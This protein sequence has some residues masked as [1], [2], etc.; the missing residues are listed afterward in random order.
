[1]DKMAADKDLSAISPE[2]N[3]FKRA[4]EDKKTGA[5]EKCLE[6]FSE[7]INGEILASLRLMVK[8]ARKYGWQYIECLNDF[9]EWGYWIRPLE[10]LYL[11][12]AVIQG[13]RPN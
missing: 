13:I 2:D 8:D 7:D 6:Q 11:K 12:Q 9:K 5:L 3:L 1:M 10:D 4:L